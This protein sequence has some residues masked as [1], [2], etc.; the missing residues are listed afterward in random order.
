MDS[1]SGKYE[2][3]PCRVC[4]C[5]VRRASNGNCVMASSHPSRTTSL[6]AERKRRGEARARGATIYSSTIPC[7]VC[8]GTVRNI[9]G[10]CAA[11]TRIRR[12]A[13]QKAR[14]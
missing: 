10:S 5:P 13:R 3:A 8:G 11:C 2:A 12:M 7:P 6:Q 9:C 14:A 4:G 1:P